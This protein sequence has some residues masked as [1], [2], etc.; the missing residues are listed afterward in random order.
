MTGELLPDL[1]I[2]VF[3][4]VIRM[5]KLVFDSIV[6]GLTAASVAMLVYLT[7]WRIKKNK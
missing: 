1:L 3:A 2:A 7:W 6:F 4:G 5:V